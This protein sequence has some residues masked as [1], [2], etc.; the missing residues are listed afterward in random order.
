MGRALVTGVVTVALS[1]VLETLVSARDSALSSVQRLQQI[2]AKDGAERA[3]LPHPLGRPPPRGSW[4]A[5]MWEAAV[6]MWRRRPWV[7]V[8]DVDQF[9]V[10]FLLWWLL[11]VAVVSSRVEATSPAGQHRA[12]RAGIPFPARLRSQSCYSIDSTAKAIWHADGDIMD[13]AVE[14]TIALLTALLS[15]ALGVRFA[16]VLVVNREEVLANIVPVDVAQAI[17]QQHNMRRGPPANWRGPPQQAR[18]PAQRLTW[19]CS[20]HSRGTRISGVHE[21]DPSVRGGRLP[22]KTTVRARQP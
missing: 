22:R 13:S 16:R 20:R 10:I 4:R 2:D 1:W 14:P 21:K 8:S 18:R 15:F 11:I 12:G 7:H 3:G 6:H 19:R 5:R 9:R 17:V